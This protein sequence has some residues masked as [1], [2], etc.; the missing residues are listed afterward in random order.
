MA[1][2]QQTEYMK[3][4]TT[5]LLKGSLA[6]MLSLGIIACNKNDNPGMMP[7]GPD[8][9]F[10]ALDNGMNLLKYNAQSPKMP[11]SNMTI[12][13][14]Q[15]GEKLIAIDFRPAT[16]Q[17]YGLGTTN[18]LYVINTN[19]G[20]AVQVG[21]VLTP[22]L[23]SGV[24]GFDFNPTVDRIRVVT[25]NGQNLRLHPETGAVVA[26]DGNINGVTNAMITGVAYDNNFAGT[27]TTTL[28]DIDV[29]TDMLYKQDP[30]N[31]GTIVAI[32][33]L[34]VDFN[35][36]TGFD[37]A[38]GN[39]IALAT[40]DVKG[41]TALYMIDLATGK[42]K[43]LGNLGGG[44]NISAIA[45]PTE[46][47]AYAIS[48]GT[49]LLIFNP[50]KPAPIIKSI[51]GLQPGEMI[52][53]I[54]FRPLN[55]QLYALGSSSK[56]YTINSANGSASSVGALPLST[57]LNGNNF[58]FDF[59]PTVD[60]IRVVSDAGQ[61]LRLNPDNGMVAAIDGSLNPGMP[62]VSAAAYTNNFA[63]ATITTL[64]DIDHA[65]DKLYRQDPP[66]AGTLVEVGSLGLNIEGTN[67]FD[68]GGK[69][70]MGWA[71]LNSGGITKLYRIDLNTGSASAQGNYVFSSSI[72]GFTVGLGN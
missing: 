14:M 44:S 72:T 64:F 50:D 3:K 5:T 57:I 17:L 13:G 25:S 70:G 34:G 16:G 39:K 46:P 45:I 8:I 40:N 48:G 66:N 67:G 58:G 63:G 68:I 65:T 35:G 59:N 18:R 47:V 69:S 7:E 31:N 51:T 38:P 43:S 61:N 62:A 28:F 52:V 15:T 29:Q 36:E 21:P 41:K 37:I 49:N 54:D 24:A 53:G 19:S 56:L 71:I 6:A 12:N 1:H 11:E 4:I 2:N 30:P 23:S 42:A 26:T 60:R 32:G 20:V 22:S 55:G 9:L 10:Y 27:T 33:D